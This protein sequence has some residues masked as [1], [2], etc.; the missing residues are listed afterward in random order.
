MFK[1][2]I[3]PLAG[4]ALAKEDDQHY[5]VR[6]FGD[7]KGISVQSVD[8]VQFHTFINHGL[9][10][11]QGYVANSKNK[12]DLVKEVIDEDILLHACMNLELGLSNP[13]GEHVA[14]ALQFTE[15]ALADEALFKK[16]KEGVT[17]VAP[18]SDFEGAKEVCRKIGA[19]KVLEFYEQLEAR[20]QRRASRID[21]IQIDGILSCTGGMTMRRT[22]TFE[23]TQ[24]VTNP[25]QDK[26]CR[27]SSRGME[28]FPKGQLVAI[29]EHKY[30]DN[31]YVTRE[32]RF[33]GKDRY[34][35]YSHNTDVFKAVEPFLRPVD[36]S[37]ESV[38]RE[39][40]G[41]DCED[42]LFMLYQRG[43]ISLNDIRKMQDD[44]DTLCKE[45]TEAQMEAF[46]RAKKRPA[47][48]SKQALAA[49]CN[50]VS[51]DPENPAPSGCDPLYGK[52]MDSADLG[53]N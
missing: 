8:Y 16:I 31:D 33:I 34:D 3:Y 11:T 36:D 29:S 27:R 15:E 39:D 50:A 30:T 53:E 20:K 40:D 47:G 42:M 43:K 35:K 13:K 19:K 44:Y 37:F 24:D 41:A 5:I 25:I 18:D 14:E 17:K 49:V 23:L 22:K 52:R 12:E 32:L 9:Q 7:G 6:D 46:H 4:A 26:R 45:G 2:T 21:P 10:G 48:G 1:A 51:T 38:L 28:V